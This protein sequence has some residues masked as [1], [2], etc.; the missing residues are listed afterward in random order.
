MKTWKFP[1]EHEIWEI[2]LMDMTSGNK[3]N[4][5]CALLQELAFTCKMFSR[6]FIILLE[7]LRA[8]LSD[9]MEMTDKLIPWKDSFVKKVWLIRTSEL[10]AENRFEELRLLKSQLRCCIIPMLPCIAQENAQISS[11]KQRSLHPPTGYL[12]LLS[13][14]NL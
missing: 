11:N 10:Y 13:N 1:F 14:L 12:W 4:Y 5:M 3:I 8:L 6:C 7:T 9:V 2:F